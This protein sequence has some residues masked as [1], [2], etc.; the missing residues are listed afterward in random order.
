[1]TQDDVEAPADTGGSDG[2]TVRKTTHVESGS[3][4]AASRRRV[5]A[6]SGAVATAGLAGCSGFLGGD[7]GSGGNEQF[8]QEDMGS[9]ATN[10]VDGIEIVGWTSETLEE[11]FQVTVTVRNTGDQTTGL[12]DYGYS[13]TLYDESG[14]KLPPRGLL[15]R[16]TA[17]DVGSGE[18]GDL[19]LDITGME[20][21][22]AVAEYEISVECDGFS[23][24]VYCQ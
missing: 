12:I 9:V 5:L 13:L 6:A 23:D 3:D 4:H 16:S 11:S 22:D 15:A 19:R 14:S 21:P 20:N 1:M 10:S 2:S 7:G 24:G 17:G 18:T 8:T